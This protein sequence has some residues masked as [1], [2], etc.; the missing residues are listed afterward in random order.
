[1]SSSS[2]IQQ[3]A[4]LRQHS[5]WLGLLA[6]ALFAA[7]DVHQAVIGFD[8]RFVLFAQEMLRNGPSFFPTTYGEPYADYSA[9]STLFIYLLSL[10]FGQVDSLT[11]WLPTSIASAAL[12][13]LLYRLLAPYSPQWALASITLLATSVMFVS[14]TRAVSLDQMLAAVA[15]GVFYLAYACDHFGAARRLVWIFA[16]LALGFAI[17]GPIGLII[18]TGMLCS[19]YLLSGQWRR[20][21]AT[22]FGALLLL[23]I[24]VAVLLWMA[25]LA[26]GDG[27]VQDVIRM[28]VLGRIDGREG[29]SAPLYYFVSS[30]G[31]YAPAYPLALIV[32]AVVLC[33]RRAHPAPALRL[34][35]FSAAAGLL[36]MVGLSI[37]LA[38]K[39]RYI[40][41]MLPMAAV[42]AGYP[43]YRYAGRLVQ[44][45]RVLMLGLWLLT[46]GLLIAALLWL[47]GRYPDDLQA[48]TPALLALAALQG[49]A[50]LMACRPSWRVAGLGASAA[51]AIWTAYSLIAQPVLHARYDTRAFTDRVQQALQLNPLPLVLQGMPKDG[52]AIKFMVNLDAPLQ[53][54]FSDSPAE[55]AAIQSPAYVVLSA[56]QYERL[57]PD[58]AKAMIEVL[59]GRFDREDYRLMQLHP[60]APRT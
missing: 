9:T 13:T 18:P 32:G 47:Q 6:L 2:C 56:A 16:L 59:S 49:L 43:F 14:E 15:F 39:A 27:F 60:Q 25:Y 20:L 21:W 28:Q 58:L 40:L 35:G 5:L 51:V 44:V 24:C 11:A 19:Y 34:L 23:G 55:L 26:G 57:P 31:N 37:P 30:L 22:G 33:Q 54:Q 4:A 17:R 46:P 41:P 1:M 45:V 42:I 53:P 36:V 7:G 29:A 38:K 3:T 50:L 12:V 8:S 52:K 48:L 10:P